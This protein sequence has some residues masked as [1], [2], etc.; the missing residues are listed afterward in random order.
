[1]RPLVAWLPVLPLHLLLLGVCLLGDHLLLTLATPAARALADSGTHAAV[2]ALCW[3]LV[4]SSSSCS[5]HSCSCSAHSCSCWGQLLLSGVLSSAID[6]DHFI[7]ARSLHLKVCKQ[8]EK[9]FL[10]IY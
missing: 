4:I 2:A 9:I 1:M 3:A 7:L 6:V 8:C 5:A 10:F